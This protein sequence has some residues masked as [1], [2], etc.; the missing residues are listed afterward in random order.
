MRRFPVLISTVRA[1]P[2]RDTDPLALDINCRA[3][4]A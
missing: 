1:I 3:V 4:H 2:V